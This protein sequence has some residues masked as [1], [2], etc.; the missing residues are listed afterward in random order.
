MNAAFWILGST[1]VIAALL[2]VLARKT[3]AKTGL[4]VFVFGLV[5]LAGGTTLIVTQAEDLVR[6]H[7]RFRW[8]SVQGVVTVSKVAGERA[9]HPHIEY[10]YSVGGRTYRDSTTLDLP[11]FGG[12]RSKYD[13]AEF[14]ASQYPVG[15]KVTVH[16]N[17]Q[18]PSESNLRVFPSWAVYGKMSVGILLSAFGVFCAIGF[19]MRRPEAVI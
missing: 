1:A 12:R 13:A 15:R 19:F 8:P 3:A 10:E 4:K 2:A 14:V 18:N 9:F 5:L 16:Y 17:P 6:A 7:L 11:S